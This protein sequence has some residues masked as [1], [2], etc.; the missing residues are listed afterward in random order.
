MPNAISVSRQSV[1]V[2]L[3]ASNA[4]AWAEAPFVRLSKELAA[5]EYHFGAYRFKE[6][7]VQVTDCANGASSRAMKPCAKAA[8]CSNLK[9]VR[10][11]RIPDRWRVARSGW[12]HL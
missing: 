1:Q 3:P 12:R 7:R 5:N 8:S 11:R 6:C 9:A 2:R 10:A 4:A